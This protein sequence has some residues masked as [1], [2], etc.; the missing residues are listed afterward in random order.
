MKVC[1]FHTA[2]LGDLATA[3]LMIDA[4][5]EAN[6][7]ISLVTNSGGAKIYADDPRIF[8]WIVVKKKSGLQKIKAILE[9]SRQLRACK[10][11]VLITPHKSFTTGL[12]AW[13]SQVPRRIAFK[14]CSLPLA[15]SELREFDTTLHESLRCLKLIPEWMISQDVRLKCER[16]ARPV[17]KS[18]S[19]MPI[20][21]T[22]LPNFLND[23]RPFF[24]VS[25]GSVWKTKIYPPGALAQVVD[26][27]LQKNSDLR[28]LVSSG[29]DDTEVVRTFLG[30]VGHWGNRVVDAA[31]CLPLNEIVAVTERAQFVISNDSSPLH[32]ASGVNV[33]VVGIFGPTSAKS[34]FGPAGDRKV[35][36]AYRDEQGAALSCQPC[37]A[38]G[39]NACPLG[40]HRCMQDLKPEVVA[41]AVFKLVPEIF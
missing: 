8:N 20:F 18:T 36:V 31:H 21:T 22:A 15:F 33:P 19:T 39:H 3:G 11:D 7:E 27:L 17:L 40:H 29:P 13:F 14:N 2:F 35:V 37:S 41:A 5:Y 30:A 34:G 1:V 4:L 38:H 26:L 9:I 32:V 24:V 23:S 16:L 25:P 10:F 6:H 12:I 28:C